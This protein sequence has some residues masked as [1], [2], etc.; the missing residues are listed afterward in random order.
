[1]YLYIYINIVERLKGSWMMAARVLKNE[2]K[3]PRYSTFQPHVKTCSDMS[4][5]SLVES[6]EHASK[7]SLNRFQPKLFFLKSYE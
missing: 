4:I 1:M 7:P 5:R 6:V 2:K 3:A